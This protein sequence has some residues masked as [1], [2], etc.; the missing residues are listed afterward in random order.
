MSQLDPKLNTDYINSQ[1]NILVKLASLYGYTQELKIHTSKNWITLKIPDTSERITIKRSAHPQY[2]FNPNNDMDKGRAFSF[3]LNRLEGPLN[4]I[5]SPT[6]AEKH[7]V[8]EKASEILNI[9]KD[10]INSIT[11]E[12]KPKAKTH[13]KES[14]LN[15]N[16][17]IQPLRKKA[18]L[19][20]KR[21]IYPSVLDHPKFNKSIYNA[22]K[23][24]STGSFIPNI[25]FPKRNPESFEITGYEIRNHE[26]KSVE[27][28]D[29]HLWYSSI[30]KKIDK[31]AIVES[32]INALSHYQ[33]F[34][35]QNE[36]T[37][38][39][40]IG[41]SLSE[42]KLD[43]LIKT[44]ERL[45]IS[46]IE[47]KNRTSIAMLTDNDAPGITYDYKIFAK[48]INQYSKQHYIE[49]AR[50]NNSI[51]LHIHHLNK[52][53][54]ETEVNYKKIKK[55]SNEFNNHIDSQSPG[56]K[57]F[58]RREILD[59]QLPLTLKTD[60]TI[61]TSLKGPLQLLNSIYS[62]I[63]VTTEKSQLKDWNDDLKN[64]KKKVNKKTNERITN[65][66]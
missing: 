1:S 6:G 52:D 47:N 3:I 45:S 59:I 41:G 35:K 12:I 29:Y 31:V 28:T 14:S 66:I 2:Y 58:Q 9:P 64:F 60:K 65:R 54:F 24:T 53:V 48:L 23:E 62:P 13:Q 50:E 55:M 11:K 19:T 37:L 16:L 56:L 10:Q 7:K 39:I 27:G 18:F 34:A 17:N 25:A 30:P 46:P 33:L 26:F 43:S 51:N 4:V 22:F 49:V 44:F 5:Q 57:V 63:H 40:S 36:N 61:N 20:V 8:F 15:E 32:A 21:H 38:Y 42:Q